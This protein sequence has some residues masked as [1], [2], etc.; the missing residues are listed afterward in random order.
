KKIGSATKG[1][2]LSHNFQ[3]RQPGGVQKV[4]MIRTG[5]LRQEK[6]PP[7][8]ENF[9]I[10]GKETP[11][12]RS[13]GFRDIPTRFFLRA[14]THYAPQCRAVLDQIALETEGLQLPTSCAVASCMRPSLSSRQVAAGFAA[15]TPYYATI[16]RRPH[17]TD[18]DRL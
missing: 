17:P 18:L 11:P 7:N 10:A 3:P 4:A 15:V 2:R 9:S 6:Y 16:A 13:G 14:T 1:R 12:P 5:T 8:R